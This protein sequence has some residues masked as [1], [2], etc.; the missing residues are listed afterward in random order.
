MVVV[1]VVVVVVMVASSN[2]DGSS[3]SHD[4]GYTVKPIEELWGKKQIHRLSH[5]RLAEHG[6]NLQSLRRG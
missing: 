5:L 4:G 6:S 3:S 1:I 2:G